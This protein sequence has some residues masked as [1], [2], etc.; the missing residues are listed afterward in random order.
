MPSTITPAKPFFAKG[1][2]MM[3]QHSLLP[4][5]QMDMATQY[6]A[7]L[8]VEKCARTKS[9]IL[10]DEGRVMMVSPTRLK[11]IGT[12]SPD[13]IYPVRTL[14]QAGHVLALSRKLRST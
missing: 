5:S 11:T 12:V 1:K 6:S 4:L 10:T 14:E 8:L 7:E 9:V 3:N 13:W 2:A